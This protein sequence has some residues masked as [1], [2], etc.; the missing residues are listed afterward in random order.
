MLR[1]SRQTKAS[2][3]SVVSMFRP[4]QLLHYVLASLNVHHTLFVRLQIDRGAKGKFARKTLQ[5]CYV[6]HDIIRGEIIQH[7]ALSLIAEIEV[8]SQGHRKT[9]KH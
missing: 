4:K 2:S 8:P 6:D 1:T 3:G 5:S 7:I 9:C